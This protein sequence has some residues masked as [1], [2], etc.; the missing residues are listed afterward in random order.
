[1]SRY[2]RDQSGQARGQMNRCRIIPV[3]VLL[4]YKGEESDSLAPDFYD[5]ISSLSD[6]KYIILFG[7]RGESKVKGVLRRLE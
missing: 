6:H 1:M 2:I 7:G 5:F 4:C 3:L